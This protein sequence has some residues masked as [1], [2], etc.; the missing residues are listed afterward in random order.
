MNE[1]KNNIGDSTRLIYYSDLIDLFQRTLDRSDPNRKW[2]FLDEQAT[3]TNEEILDPGNFAPL[4]A[5]WGEQA[6]AVLAK[7]FG[8]Y[9]RP[10]FKSNLTSTF[11]VRLSGYVT[12]S[13]ELAALSFLTGVSMLDHTRKQIDLSAYRFTDRIQNISERRF[14]GEEIG[15]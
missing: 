1:Q 7:K 6:W 5:W 10:I 4:V 15:G 3:I 11:Q 2:M 14:L 12:T 8:G 9:A 13:P